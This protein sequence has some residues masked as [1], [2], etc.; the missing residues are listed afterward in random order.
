MEQGQETTKEEGYGELSQSRTA[1][2][3]A[4]GI[5]FLVNIANIVFS[6]LARETPHAEVFGTNVSLVVPIAIDLFLGINLLRGKQWARKWMLVRVVLGLLVWGIITILEK[7]FGG[8]VMQVG[9]CGALVLLLTG[10]SIHIR[11]AGS[12]G[13]F[14]LSFVGGLVW[15]AIPPS[16]TPVE[17]YMEVSIDG[18]NA[19]IPA[20][21]TEDDPSEVGIEEILRESRGTMTAKA[22][23]EKSENAG[24]IFWMVNMRLAYELEGES[25]P[26]W[27]QLEEAEGFNKQEFCVMYSSGVLSEERN[28]IRKVIRA[29][30]LGN[31]EAYELLYTAEFEGGPAHANFLYV[32]G[33]DHLGIGYLVCK[34]AAW[35]TFQECW[36]RIRDSVRL[37]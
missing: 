32:F 19:S 2:W 3:I 34:E 20:D 16:A 8:L 25:W 30:T 13:L 36:P 14:V 22:Y 5:I 4:V 11:L 24:L 27:Q 28:V 15:A 17:S 6:V 31:K 33:E 23:T 1:V 7:D 35:P 21:W 9:F 12:V 18:L 37:K 29:L 26:G 10:T